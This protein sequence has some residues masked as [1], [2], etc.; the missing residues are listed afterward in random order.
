[1]EGELAASSLD[2]YALR[3]VK[4]RDDPLTRNVQ[5]RHRFVMKAISGADVAWHILAL[6]E[7]PRPLRSPSFITEGRG[8]RP[9]A[10]NGTDPGREL[11]SVAGA[12]GGLCPRHVLTSAPGPLNRAAGRADITALRKLL[13]GR[14]D[15]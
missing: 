2:W 11:P 12:G 15:R 5:A 8:A 1:M 10:R 9:R 6:A 3:P 4:L 13:P 7:D 14:G